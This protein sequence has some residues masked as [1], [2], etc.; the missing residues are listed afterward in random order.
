MILCLFALSL[1]WG[2]CLQVCAIIAGAVVS[3]PEFSAVFDSCEG[4]YDVTMEEKDDYA[5]CVQSQL[6]RCGTNLE[7]SAL[8]ESERMII[9][10]DFNRDLVVAAKETQKT[11][12]S[13]FTNTRYSL[14][15]WSSNFATPG[16][17]I[18]ELPYTPSCTDL[19]KDQITS[20]IG[21]ISAVRSEAFALS[22]QYSDDSQGAVDRLSNYAMLRAQYDARYVDNHTQHMQDS[23]EEWVDG[24]YLPSLNLNE[25]FDGLFP[26]VTHLMSCVTPRSQVNESCP[27][28]KSAYEMLEE[29]RSELESARDDARETV[30]EFAVKAEQY[31]VSLGR[32]TPCV[33][34]PHVYGSHMCIAH[35]CM[36]GECRGGVREL[37]GVLR[38]G[39]GGGCWGCY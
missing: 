7:Q 15:S 31:Q 34:L 24:I 33:W 29:T 20:E 3:I 37:E 9:A 1:M 23:F 17:G 35:I 13:A 5:Q 27:Y 18:T 36:A 11:C 16:S 12:S 2:S 4:A 21:D 10:N 6:S 28:M 19:Q 8:R 25:T 26:D 38:G 30:D 22:T 32:E 39:Q 14:E